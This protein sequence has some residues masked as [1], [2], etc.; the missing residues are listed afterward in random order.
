MSDEWIE[1]TLDTIRGLQALKEIHVIDDFVADPERVR[2]SALRSGFGT[3]HPNKGDVGA[4]FYEGVNFMGDHTA[5]QRSLHAAVGPIIVSSMFFRVTNP[6]MER[7]LIH[8]DREYG[9]NTAIVYLSPEPEGL[10]GTA[11][12]RHRQTGWTDMPALSDLMK[13]ADFS[14]LRQQMLDADDKDWEMIQFVEGEYN[15]CIIFDAPKI[16]CRIP[17]V[18]FGSTETDSRMCWVCH[19]DRIPSCA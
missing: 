15:R 5:L 3:W 10:S 4:S 1:S 2:Q 12:Y 17:Q 18:G 16:H 9:Q 7:A 13:R 14:E 19:F 11:F 8:S 6:N